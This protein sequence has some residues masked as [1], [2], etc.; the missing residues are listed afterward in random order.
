MCPSQR[1]SWGSLEY[2]IFLFHQLLL[3]SDWLRRSKHT[4]AID[5]C[6]IKYIVNGV[7]WVYFPKIINTVTENWWQDQKKVTR[8]SLFKLCFSMTVHMQYYV[9]LASAVQHSGRT[10]IYLTKCP[11]AISSTHRA[12]YMVITYHWL[13]SLCCASHP[14]DCCVATDRHFS[15]PSPFS[16]SPQ[17]PS[18]QAALRLFSVSRSLFLFRFF[19]YQ[20]FLIH[21]ENDLLVHERNMFGKLQNRLVLSP[22]HVAHRSRGQVFTMPLLRA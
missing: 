3:T 17:P 18:L 20:V 14:C 19:I 6:P 15:T 22:F 12:P 9:A 21:L 5:I 13:Y 1:K 2:W 4:L 10:I 7:F 16:S 8:F 11:P